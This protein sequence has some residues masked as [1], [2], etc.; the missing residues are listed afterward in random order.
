MLSGAATLGVVSPHGG[1]AGLERK[2]LAPIRMVPVTGPL[3]PL[4]SYKGEI[5]TARLV[6]A[7]Q[8]VLSERAVS[9]T[10]DQGVL[11]PRTWRVADLTTKHAMLRANL[12]W[13]NLPWNLAEDDL[14]SGALV[15]I[16]PAAWGEEEHQ[17]YLSAVY[18]RDTTFGPA[19][20]WL[21]AQLELL[22]FR[23]ASPADRATPLKRTRR[24]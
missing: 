6:D 18:R 20:R 13:G 1:V 14:Q 15:A 8:I 3:H 23:D 24:R 2:V 16:R 9:G 5:P 22:C 19:H 12:G 17:L 7:V 10:P 11:S 4:A 21:L